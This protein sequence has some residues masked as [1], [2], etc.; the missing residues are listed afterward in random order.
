MGRAVSAVGLET[1]FSPVSHQATS[2]AGGGETSPG[3]HY[4]RTV[5]HQCQWGHARRKMG[6]LS[7]EPSQTLSMHSLL[8]LTPLQIK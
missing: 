3:W 6:A 8:W 2:Q 1:E 7:L 4:S 5:T